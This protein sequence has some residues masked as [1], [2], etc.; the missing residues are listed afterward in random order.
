MDV[1]QLEFFLAVAEDGSFTRAAERSFVS[2]PGLSASIRSLERELRVGLFERGRHGA[3]P[4]AGGAAFR[5][6]AERIL[7]E[8]REA[9]AAVLGAAAPHAALRIGSEQCLGGSVDIADLVSAF[10]GEHPAADLE[11]V[12]DV[13]SR[14]LP[15]VAAGRLDVAL[16]AAPAGGEV[17]P[18]HQVIRREPFVL[19]SKEDP[20]VRSID[21]LAG[22]RTV[23]F[24]P[25]WEAR[26]ILD[27]ALARAG[28]ERRT[29]VEV[30]DVHMV[31]E[32][33]TRGFGVAVVPESIAAKQSADH[34]LH[35]TLAGAPEWEVRVAVSPRPAPGA[36]AFARM[37][38][39]QSRIAGLAADLVGA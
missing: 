8:V 4:T 25:A 19:L 7:G 32:L 37:F 10:A 24:G 28:V 1:R 14:L 38:V 21:D 13:T 23:D 5:P 9:Q 18:G 29:T 6:W 34:L 30:G 26:R 22:A 39:P 36:E 31:F 35:S 33:V 15:L 12:Q 2:Q 3:V 20:G 17:P 27:A 16:V 11:F